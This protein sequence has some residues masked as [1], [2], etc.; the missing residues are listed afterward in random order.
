MDRIV[1]YFISINE[2]YYNLVLDRNI[3]LAIVHNRKRILFAGKYGYFCFWH[4]SVLF[5]FSLTWH[6][7]HILRIVSATVR[8]FFLSRLPPRIRPPTCTWMR[9]GPNPNFWT[10]N[11]FQYFTFLLLFILYCELFVYVR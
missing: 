7:L 11:Y 2:F 5:C 8:Q 3:Y 6:V 10:R 9:D 1:K 4:C